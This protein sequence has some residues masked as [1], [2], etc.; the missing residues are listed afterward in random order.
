MQTKLPA[1]AGPVERGVGPRLTPWFPGTAKPARVGLYRAQDTTMNCGC[2][3]FDLMWTGYEWR[4]ELLTP[5]R[6]STHYFAQAH[7]KRWRG[8]V[9]RPNVRANRPAAAGRAWARMK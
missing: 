4:S 2:C 6:W 7:L 5:G 9:E 1:V 8:L 3:W